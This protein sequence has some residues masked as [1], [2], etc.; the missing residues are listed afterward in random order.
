[1]ELTFTKVGDY[2]IP[3]LALDDDTEYEIGICGRMQEKFLK[4]HHPGVYNTVFS[5]FSCERLCGIVRGL[6]GKNKGKIHVP[7]T[8][9][10]RIEA[11]TNHHKGG[12]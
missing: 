11:R 3:D 4:E 12:R 9:A 6:K 10:D 2:Y 1:M 7:P 8:K 5:G